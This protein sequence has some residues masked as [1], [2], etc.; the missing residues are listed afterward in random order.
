ME[1]KNSLIFIFVVCVILIFIG[2][3][4]NTDWLALTGIYLGAFTIIN[5]LLDR[6]KSAIKTTINP[7]VS[8]L[9]NLLAIV[10]IGS[11]AWNNI[12]PVF[13]TF[14]LSTVFSI[15]L[16]L[17]IL[18]RFAKLSK[19]SNI[20]NEIITRTLDYKKEMRVTK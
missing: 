10:V 7:L 2:E 3:V 13:A 18:R 11:L 17:S 9:L 6:I 8:I 12:I 19:K 15:T 20:A 4:K 16:T 1:R 5:I 14:I